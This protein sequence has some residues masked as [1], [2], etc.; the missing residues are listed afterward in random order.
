MIKPFFTTTWCHPG[1]SH[2]RNRGLTCNIPTSA[3]SMIGFAHACRRVDVFSPEH[4]FHWRISLLSES[5]VKGG[6][7]H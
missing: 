6:K 5:V 3:C 7:P 1:L 4:V 2:N